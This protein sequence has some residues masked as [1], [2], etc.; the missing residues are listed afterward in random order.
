MRWKHIESVDYDG[1]IE[2]VVGILIRSEDGA[3]SSAGDSGGGC[4]AEFEG[5]LIFIGT[6]IGAGK[7]GTV[8]APVTQFY[9]LLFG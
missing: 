7:H 9:N 1:R 2:E 3:F 6:I 5:E 4:F 8:V